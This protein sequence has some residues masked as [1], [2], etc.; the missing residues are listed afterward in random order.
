MA[1]YFQF[2]A[3]I[4]RI[5]NDRNKITRGSNKLYYPELEIIMDIKLYENKTIIIILIVI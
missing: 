4:P 3:A 5:L 1:N 2:N